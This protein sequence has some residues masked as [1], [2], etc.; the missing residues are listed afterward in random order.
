MLEN[1]SCTGE[2]DRLTGNDMIR[3]VF[4]RT[5]ENRENLLTVF[6]KYLIYV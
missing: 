2:G 3:R 1:A 6:E 4:L 5:R